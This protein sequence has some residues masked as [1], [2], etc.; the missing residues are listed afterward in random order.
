MQEL[1][2]LLVLTFIFIGLATILSKNPVFSV[3]FLVLSFC[4]AASI[5]ILFNVELLAALFI[6]I[7]VGAIAVLFLFVVMMLDVKVY[8]LGIFSFIFFLPVVNF[9][10]F[11]LLIELRSIL[12]EVFCDI[13]LKAN[14]IFNFDTVDNISLY[15]QI[16]YN[17][18][19]VCCLLAGIILLVAMVG[20]IVLTLNFKVRNTELFS[21]QLSKSDY[22]SFFN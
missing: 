9:F 5:L 15:G 14:Y 16:F 13:S 1:H 21:K 19:L 12:I 6:I 17:N 8:P 3:L 22:L 20:A 11:L 7:Y 10:S 2:F 4:N 18:F